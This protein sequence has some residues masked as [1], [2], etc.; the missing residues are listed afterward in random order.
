[1]DRIEFVEFGEQIKKSADLQAKEMRRG[2]ANIEDDL[3]VAI[4]LY[5]GLLIQGNDAKAE[6]LKDEPLA[7]TTQIDRVVLHNAP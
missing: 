6:I 2:K 1:M 4:E 7:E 5:K 3:R